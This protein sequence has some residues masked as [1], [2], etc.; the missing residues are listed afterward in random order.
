MF[1]HVKSTTIVSWIGP[2][3][4]I[5]HCCQ[6]KAMALHLEPHDYPVMLYNKSKSMVFVK[7]WM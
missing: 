6:V 4:L 2:Y 1:F 3:Q 5:M 7:I